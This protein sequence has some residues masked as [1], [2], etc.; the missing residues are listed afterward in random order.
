MPKAI[1]LSDELMKDAAL[2]GKAEH[3]STPKQIEHWA[4]L[5]KIAEENPDMPLAFI[6]G[7]LIS[8]EQEKAGDVSA[9]EF[10]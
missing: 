3:R 10:G 4:K 5:G 8:I 9:Y 7:V 2:Y 6:K 1:R